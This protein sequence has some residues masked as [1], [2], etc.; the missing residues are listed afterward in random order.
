VDCAKGICILMVVMMHSTLGVEAAAG[1]ESWMHEF[2]AFARPF[3]MPD[4]FLIAGLF[5]ARRIDRGWPDYIDRKVFHFVYFYLLWLTVQFV[6]K[7]PVL[8][9]DLGPLGIL[10]EYSHALVQ[11]YGTLWFIYLLPIFF[12]V[13]KGLRTVSMGVVWLL[14]AMLEISGLHTGITVIDEFAG[15]FVY[16][17][18]G[19]ALA[20]FVF[21][22]AEQVGAEPVK[23]FFGLAGW[24]LLNEYCVQAGIAEWPLVSLI[25]G[26]AGAGAVIA[27]AVLLSRV[28]WGNALRYCGENS[29]VIYLAF[30]V[31][32]A[33]TR[34]V[35][36]KLGWISD[37]GSVALLVTLAGLTGALVLY[38]IVR[39][40]PLSFLFE[41]PDWARLATWQRHE[42][43]SLT[44]AS[45]AAGKGT[46]R[47]AN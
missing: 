9:S 1:N 37:L 32:M 16:F 29:I 21:R 7:S 26:F 44:A 5:L 38:W 31:P 22:F 20:P 19:Y 13:T 18:T 10:R 4:F 30:T 28:V 8:I 36:L 47:A 42:T 23:S 40:T 41:R 27:I 17:Y 43:E 6:L 25:L 14:A 35:L 33:A 39:N 3:R 24:A 15:R 46:G 45:S 2:V 12:V 34:I 11:P